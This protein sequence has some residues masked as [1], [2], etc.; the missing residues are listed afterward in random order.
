VDDGRECDGPVH[1]DEQGERREQQRAKPEPGEE[2]QPRCQE[3]D[4][5]DDDVGEKNFLQIGHSFAANKNH[6]SYTIAA[7]GDGIVTA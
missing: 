4:P 7:V 3:R 2:R 1:R 5:A 6:P